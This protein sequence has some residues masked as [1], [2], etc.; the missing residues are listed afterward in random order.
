VY[1]VINTKGELVDRVQ[2]PANR[3][4]VGFGADGVVYMLATEGAK[5]K[6]ERARFK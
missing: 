1:D 4:V 5:R 6:L 3:V 2:L